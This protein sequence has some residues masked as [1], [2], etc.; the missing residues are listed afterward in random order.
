VETSL[1]PLDDGGG[2]SMGAGTAAN[3]QTAT[4]YVN[5]LRPAKVADEPTPE[6]LRRLA[7]DMPKGEDFWE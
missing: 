6:W 5:G 2:R 4:Q 7:E 3:T 1:R